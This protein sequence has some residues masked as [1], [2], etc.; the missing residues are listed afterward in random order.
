MD[1]H[2]VAL[3]F[4][5]VLKMLK[6]EWLHLTLINKNRLNMILVQRCMNW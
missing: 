2:Y 4:D 5:K 3:E 6:E 1:K